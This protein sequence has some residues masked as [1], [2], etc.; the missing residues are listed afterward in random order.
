MKKNMKKIIIMAAAAAAFISTAAYASEYEGTYEG[1]YYANQGQTGLTLTINGDDT[2]V[3][4]FY[5]MPGKS[6]AKDGS[7]SVTVSENSDGILEVKGDKWIKQ[8]SGYSFVS[9]RGT[10]DDNGVYSGIVSNNK[11]WSFVLNKNNESYQQI[12]DSVHENHKYMLFDE[13]LT[14]HEAKSACEAKGGHLAT[15]GSKEEQEYIEKLVEAGTKKQYWIGASRVDGGFEWVTGESFDYTNWDSGEPNCHS[16][17]DGEKEDYAQMYNEPNPAMGGS[18]RFKWNDIYYDNIYPGEESFFSTENAS[19]ICEWETWSDAAQWSTPELQKAAENNLIPDVLVGKDMTAPI[20][21]GEFAAVSV[22]LFEAMTG[23]KSV[24]SSECKFN[25]IASNENRNYILKAYNIG[26][27][28]GMSDTEY[29]PDALLLR[30]QLAAMLTR[31]YKKSEWPEWT[32][33]EDDNYTI[34]YSGVK[35]FSDD[36]YISDYAKPSVYFMVKYNVLSGIGDNK[37]APKNTTPAQEAQGYA[38]A[39]R[40]QAVV[41]SLRSFENLND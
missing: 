36:E 40:E 17:S 14:W 16:R 32:L 21:R 37:F 34:N 2:G 19:Y 28:N 13:P 3:F 26:A 35:K 25:D 39:T 15:I 6:N 4:E 20:T 12:V 11:Q 27:V 7:Y 38:N 10:L 5:N 8:P 23:G 31:V 30:E 33:A 22:K 24:M 9:L 29:K 1:W 18:K 41:M